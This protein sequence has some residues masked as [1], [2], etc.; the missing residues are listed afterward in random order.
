M[1]RS[2]TAGLL[3][4]EVLLVDLGEH[5]LRDLAETQRVFQLGDDAFPPLRGLETFRSNLPSELSSFV[6]RDSELQAVAKQLGAGRVVSIVGVGGMGKTGL[7]LHVASDLLPNYG[8]GVW[9]CELAS[10]TEPGSIPD[11]VASA[12]GYA[13]AQG[14]PVADGLL[15]FLE[16]KNLLLVL[17]NCEHLIDA[18]AAFVTATTAAAAGVSVL[19][20]SREGLGVRGEQ[21]AYGR[22]R[23]RL[24]Q[25]TTTTSLFG[26]IPKLTRARVRK[27]GDAESHAWR[28]EPAIRMPIDSREL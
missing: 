11:A 5:R 8:D 13:P 18:A 15:R 3:D 26:L 1:A 9:V 20:T 23:S 14:V 16:R 21:I 27:L 2:T 19:V 7:A 25:L 28:C 6:G 17:D 24:S 22:S 10:V 12:L 4:T